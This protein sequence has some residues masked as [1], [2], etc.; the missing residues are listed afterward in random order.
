[1]AHYDELYE[2]MSLSE[3]ESEYQDLLKQI[4]ASNEHLEGLKRDLLNSTSQY[5]IDLLQRQIQLVSI[6]LEQRLPI[7]KKR[8]ESLIKKAKSGEKISYSY[9]HDYLMGL[10]W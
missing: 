7:L 8:M 1:M 3:L 5:T 6:S 4:K 9:K 2:I 10:I